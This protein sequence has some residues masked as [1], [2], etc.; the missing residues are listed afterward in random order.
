MKELQAEL[1]AADTLYNAGQYD[2]AIAAYQ[3]IMTKAPSL[4]VIN[5][6]IGTAYRQ[7]KE[8][9]KALTAF[10][11][12]LKS[13]PANEKARVAIGMTHLEIGATAKDEAARQQA[14]AE[15]DK[16]LTEAAVSPGATREVLYSLGEVKF[17]KSEMEQA[18][19]WYQKASELDP[20][21]GKPLFKLGLVA[22]NKGDKAG[23]AS[24]FEKVVAADPNSAEAAQAKAVIDQL[25]K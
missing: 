4:T 11:E 9:D 17:A 16:I 7:K 21:W 3:A 18:A 23:A 5:L 8:Y 2:E 20:S 6:Q 19:Q 13:D 15:A 14:F 10:A 25:K 12:A 22:L 1:Q 24:Y